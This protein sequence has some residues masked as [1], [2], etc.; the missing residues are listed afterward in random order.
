MVGKMSLTTKMNRPKNDEINSLYSNDRATW[1]REANAKMVQSKEDRINHIKIRA[2]TLKAKR[3][4]ERLEHVKNCYQKQWRDQNDEMRAL[5]S[6]QMLDQIQLGRKLEIQRKVHMQHENEENND[7]HVMCILQNDDEDESDQQSKHHN[8]VIETRRALDK[9]IELKQKQAAAAATQKQKEEQEQLRK[10]SALDFEAREEERRATELAKKKQREIFQDTLQR[11]KEKQERLKLEKEQDAILL[12][13]AL[14]QERE[15]ILREQAAKDNGKDAAFEYVRCLKEQTQKEEE[16]ESN[17][18]RIRDEELERIAKQHEDR[19]KAEARAKEQQLVEIKASREQQIIAKAKQEELKRRK[20]QEEVE[21]AKRG[22]Q[23]AEEA[24]KRAE[25]KAR[26]ARLETAFANKQRAHEQREQER[27]QKEKT[28]QEERDRL[29][30][31][32]L[33]YR[34]PPNNP[35]SY[36]RLK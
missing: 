5:Q 32:E 25:K 23:R 26:A 10:M 29:Q 31:L 8:K 18:N 4:A 6:K 14:R 20:E 15:A 35:P 13:N 7:T 2:Y 11:S 24:D 36:S 9:Q 33:S 21:E 17:V 27:I 34:Y 12:Q 19:I 22:Q 30:Q 16:D 28:R 3:E 1:E